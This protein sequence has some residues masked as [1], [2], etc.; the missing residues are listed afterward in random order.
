MC[1]RFRGLKDWSELPGQLGGA[2]I[3]FDYNPNVAPPERVP[4]LL[5]E[6]GQDVLTRMARFGIALAAN[7]NKNRPPLLNAR[8][9]TLRRGS[10]RSILG[11]RRCVIPSEGFY[12][13][14]EERGKSSPI[15]SNEGT[16][17]RCCSPGYGICAR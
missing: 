7:G 4:V 6:T 11:S 10:F 2:R 8:T 9:D 17:S 16:A 1:N 3:N 12:E 5:G 15:F 14:R 13:W